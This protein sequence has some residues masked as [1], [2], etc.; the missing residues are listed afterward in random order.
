MRSCLSWPL[1]ISFWPQVFDPLSFAAIQ[2]HP[3]C[4][5]LLEPHAS[6]CRAHFQGNPRFFQNITYSTLE[7]QQPFKRIR[8]GAL[9]SLP[10]KLGITH[11]WSTFHP[12]E[13]DTAKSHACR[14]ITHSLAGKA[15]HS[16]SFGLS[17]SLQQTFLGVTHCNCI[18]TRSS[19]S[20]KS[21]VKSEAFQALVLSPFD[22]RNWVR[23]K[24]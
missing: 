16:C 23:I 5:S 22:F 6:W 12:R 19:Y 20:S 13:V 9:T 14:G 18:A 24:S 11:A 10:S 2:K 15:F 1:C 7:K 3:G 17:I 4:S 21:W 8:H